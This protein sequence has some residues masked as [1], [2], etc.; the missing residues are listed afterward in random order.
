MTT[1]K[2]LLLID[3]RQARNGLMV[4]W[5]SAE[6]LAK[7]GIISDEAARL[8]GDAWSCLCNAIDEIEENEGDER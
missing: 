1:L 4:L 5:K 6:R 7:E 3:L 8:V 2:D